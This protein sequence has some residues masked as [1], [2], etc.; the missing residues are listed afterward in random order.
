MRRSMLIPVMAGLLAIAALLSRKALLSTRE[1]VFEPANKPPPLAPMCPWR[2]P[3][4]DLPRLFPEASRFEVQTRVLS[5]LRAELAKRLGRL[6]TGDE[7]ALRVY[8]VYKADRLM[9]ELVTRRVKGTFGA[10]E[11]VIGVDNGG[12]LKGILVQRL[13]EPQVVVDTLFSLNWVQWLQGIGAEDRWD[14]DGLLAVLPAEARPSVVAIIEGVRSS[15]I[16]LSISQHAHYV[17]PNHSHEVGLRGTENNRSNA[18]TLKSATL[19]HSI[20]PFHPQQDPGDASGFRLRSV[21]I[22]S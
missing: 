18:G 21:G 22:R 1:S 12:R 15:M 20:T 6:P 5:G 7:N 8:C 9:G 11:L 3:E 4:T 16:L 19:Q 2:N 13:R 14:T 17:E 10:I